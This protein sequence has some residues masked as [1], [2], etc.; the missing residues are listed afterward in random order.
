MDDKRITI[1]A[2]GKPPCDHAYAFKLSG[3]KTSITP[4]VAAARDEAMKK[5]QSDLNN[6][7][8]AEGKKQK[9]KTKTK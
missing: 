9:T 8:K 4:D 3:S 7:S 2:P 1:D 6:A 5:L